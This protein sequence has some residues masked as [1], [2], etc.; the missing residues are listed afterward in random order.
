MAQYHFFIRTYNLFK[1]ARNEYLNKSISLNDGSLGSL[2][3]EE[4]SEMRYVMWI[5]GFSESSSFWTHIALFLRN[6]YEWFSLYKQTSSSDGE[7][8]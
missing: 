3:D 4:R 6:E 1:S 7:R 2:N 5:A 8:E